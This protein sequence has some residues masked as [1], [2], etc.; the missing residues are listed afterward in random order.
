MTWQPIETAPKITG[1]QILTFGYLPES[2][3]YSDRKETISISKWCS[4]SWP[5]QGE[6]SSQASNFS[7]KFI[8]TLWMPLPNPPKGE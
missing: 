4:G 8:P 7:V 3:G 5:N 6:W 2:Y 1:E